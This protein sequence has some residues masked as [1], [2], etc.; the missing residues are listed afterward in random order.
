LI[1]K[2]VVIGTLVVVVS[3]IGSLIFITATWADLQSIN[4][5]GVI[6]AITVTVIGVI[7]FRRT[8]KS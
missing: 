1:S 4:P 2:N 5:A 8:V 3:F 7:W 6:A